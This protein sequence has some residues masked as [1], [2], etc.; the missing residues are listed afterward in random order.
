M[1]AIATVLLASCGGNDEPRVTEPP[2]VAALDKDPPAWASDAA[3]SLTAS[4]P[5]SVELAWPV[6]SDANGVRE[7]RVIRTPL[8]EA[9]EP[10]EVATKEPSLKVT[11]LR[12][13]GTYLFELLAVDNRGNWTTS[14]LRLKT[15]TADAEG[16]KFPAGASLT[17][18]EVNDPKEGASADRQQDDIRPVVDGSGR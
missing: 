16:P 14:G 8:T 17:A 11:G 4:T 3:L 13:G 7:Y 12:S 18:W 15:A 6:P 9:G 2:R 5:T 10:I 1:V